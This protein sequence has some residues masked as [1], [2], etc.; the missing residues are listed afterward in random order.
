MSHRRVPPAKKKPSAGSVAESQRLMS[1]EE[2]RE[3]IL[4]HVAARSNSKA[5]WSLGSYLGIGTCCAAVAIGWWLTLGHRITPTE[6]LR[7]D[8]VIQTLEQNVA[9]LKEQISA[10]DSGL[11]KEDWDTKLKALHQQY[12]AAMLQA[13]VLQATADQISHLTVSSTSS[14]QR[15][16]E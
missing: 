9:K 13:K 2:K 14:T 10:P 15:S 1:S 4:A 8:A 11:N 3:L 5:E 7:D 12:D 16:N 6:P